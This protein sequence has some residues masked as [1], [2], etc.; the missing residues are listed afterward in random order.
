MTSLSNK[1]NTKQINFNLNLILLS[2]GRLVSNF[3][4]SIFNFTLS[5]YVLDLTGSAAAFSTVLAFGFLPGVFVNVFAGVFVD[6]HDKKKIIVFCDLF[7]GGVILLMAALFGALS[8]SLMF[9]IIFN[10]VLGLSNSFFT[11]AANAA[12]PNIVSEERVPQAN[13]A[14]QSAGAII[15]IV[16]PI[17][18]ALMYQNLNV[19]T[20]FIITAISFILSGISEMFIVFIKSNVD[21]GELENK[22]YLSNVITVFQYLNTQKI[23]KFLLIFAV[24]INFIYNPLMVVAVRFVTFTVLGI[25]SLQLSLIQASSAIGMIGGAIFVSI[26]KSNNKLLKRFFVLLLFQSI[27]II[28]WVF[29][30]LPAFSNLSHGGITGIFMLLLFLYGAF[31]TIQN[32]PMISHFQTKI[33]EELRGRVFGVFM[34]ALTATTPLGIWLFGVLLELFSWQIVIAASGI[35][36]MLLCLYAS[37]N[38]LFKSFIKELN[39]EEIMIATKEIK[40]GE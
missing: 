24:I 12:I 23:M 38:Q 33:P 32:I 28:M 37:Q 6:K 10:A 16:G 36:M 30:V 9:I 40:V 13:S 7:S 17:T 22:S 34:T 1:D 20:I 21:K 5:L 18:G 26:Q 8:S 31:N 2:L 39:Q 4:S 14:L 11:L 15:N 3:G 27:F 35:S 25:S 29:P 19:D